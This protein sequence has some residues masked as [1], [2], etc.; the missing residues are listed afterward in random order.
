MLISGRSYMVGE[1]VSLT[2]FVDSH[3]SKCTDWQRIV[4]RYCMEYPKAQIRIMIDRPPLEYLIYRQGEFVVIAL[5][6]HD[7]GGEKTWVTQDC[8]EKILVNVD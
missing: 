1:Q 4:A 2:D 6:Y 8:R 3:T 7:K 5:P